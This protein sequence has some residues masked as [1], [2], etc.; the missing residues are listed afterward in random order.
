MRLVLDSA[1]SAFISLVKSTTMGP[2]TKRQAKC[3]APQLDLTACQCVLSSQG[4]LPDDFNTIW[5]TDFLDKGKCLRGRHCPFAHSLQQLRIDAAIERGTVQ[6]DFKTNFC[7]NQAHNGVC[8][9]LS[10]DLHGSGR[11]SLRRAQHS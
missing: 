5:C 10:Q 1:S 4:I 8:I 6:A 9:L 7:A 3:T 11:F 2:V